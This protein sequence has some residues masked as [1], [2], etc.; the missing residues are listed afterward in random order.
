MRET[1]LRSLFL[2][3]SYTAGTAVPE[4]LRWPVQLTDH[5]KA[6]GQD[7]EPPHFVAGN[8]WTTEDLLRALEAENPP[9][10]FDLVFLMIGVNNQFHGRPFADFQAQ[11]RLLVHR[12]IEF[13]RGRPSGVVVLAIPDYS[14]VP[15][16]AER[17]PAAIA[18]DI[19]RYNVECEAVSQGLGVEFL[20]TAVISR[21]AGSRPELL[22]S[23]GLHPSEEMY[24]LW[25]D[26]IF[27][28]IR[29]R[30]T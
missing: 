29:G 15:F 30:F 27:A 2:G 11:L 4:K 25:S 5:L 9:R 1:K 7:V 18:A 8:G 20:D 23:D 12:A 22:V 13:A 21:Q 19:N 3:D 10:H 14:V 6:V 16:A 24:R 17:N 26:F 28:G